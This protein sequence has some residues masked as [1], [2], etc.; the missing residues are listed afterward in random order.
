MVMDDLRKLISLIHPTPPN[1][2]FFTWLSKT[3]S[4]IKIKVLARFI[5]SIK[6]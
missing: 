3:K 5:T 6:V 2:K 4:D 1:P